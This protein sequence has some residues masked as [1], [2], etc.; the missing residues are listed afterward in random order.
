MRRRP[1]DR[2][3]V[4]FDEA[5]RLAKRLKTSRSDIYA[6]ALRAFVGDHAPDRVTD[7]MNAVLDAV[8]AQPDPVTAAAARQ[9]LARI[10]W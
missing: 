8:G 6:R 3:E 1:R 2:A 7:G 9:V 5:E 4:F 10:E